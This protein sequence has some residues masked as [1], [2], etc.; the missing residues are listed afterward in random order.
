MA[1]CR[2]R[3]F[4]GKNPIV[5][6]PRHVIYEATCNCSFNHTI[7]MRGDLAWACV[8]VDSKTDSRGRRGSVRH[9]AK[10]THS[11]PIACPTFIR[12]FLPDPV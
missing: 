4:N 6:R 10:I 1:G 7:L 2:A 12:S 5:G 3:I 9:F 8:P 11:C